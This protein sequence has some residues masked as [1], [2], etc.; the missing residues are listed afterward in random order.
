M[1]PYDFILFDE[2]A[3]DYIQAYDGHVIGL[4]YRENTSDKIEIDFNINGYKNMYGNI[5]MSKS[6]Y[7][8]NKAKILNM[9]KTLR[10]YE[11]KNEAEYRK[12]SF[13][14]INVAFEIPEYWGVG[15]RLFFAKEDYVHLWIEMG[16]ITESYPNYLTVTAGKEIDVDVSEYD[17][18]IAYTNDGREI[19]FKRPYGRKY[20]GAYEF[21]IEELKVTGSLDL[22][23][24]IYENHRDDI[25]DF[26]KSFTTAL[27]PELEPVPE[28]EISLD[29]LTRYISK[30]KRLEL[31]YPSV[32]EP[33]VY[34]T[35]D[36]Y[37]EIAFGT[38]TDIW[39]N[40]I[41]IRWEPYDE[42]APNEP[43]SDEEI[44]AREKIVTKSGLPLYLKTEEYEFHGA[45]T[46]EI[47]INI[48]NS[49]YFVGKIM[50]EKDMYYKYEKE[51]MELLKSLDISE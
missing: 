22:E 26:V 2:I 46:V 43:L 38:E 37:F 34:A 6:L 13:E 14:E 44:A 10:I 33:H 36:E 21:V 40:E 12:Y 25:I 4:Y 20:T 5:K 15:D 11:A 50:F 32:W 17:D 9:L 49:I 31:E 24:D 23:Q 19:R 8:E 7:N 27:E 47:D 18:L 16:Y 3:D 1:S 51:I 35:G 45:D 30:S 48:N 39:N 28:E 42:F 29:S 41:S